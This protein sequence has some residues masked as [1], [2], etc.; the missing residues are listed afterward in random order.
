M[1]IRSGLDSCSHDSMQR[2]R[3]FHKG[4]QLLHFRKLLLQFPPLERRQAAATAE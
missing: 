4:P 1:P 2:R 3:W